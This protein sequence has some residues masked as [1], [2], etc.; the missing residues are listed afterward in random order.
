ME[1]QFSGTSGIT[2]SCVNAVLRYLQFGDSISKVSIVTNK[3]SHALVLYTEHHEV[4]AI[5][6][7]FTS[8]YLGEGPSGFAYVLSLLN[9]QEIE[10]EE[11]YVEIKII[12]KINSSRLTD[13]ELK[14][15]EDSRPVRPTRWHDYV[16]DYRNKYADNK[17][18]LTRFPPVIPFTII[19]PRLFD[20]S[21]SFW[22][23]PSDKILAGYR[24]L[25]DVIRE[26]CDIDDHGS[27]LF[28]KAFLGENSA[29]IWPGLTSGEA[30]GR[31]NLF[32]AIYGGFRNRRA[33][34][35]IAEDSKSQLIEFLALNQLFSLESTSKL[36]LEEGEQRAAL[37]TAG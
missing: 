13:S 6:S 18:L 16:Y 4:I 15:I 24:R 3:Q 17:A 25:E 34:K 30:A 28:Q 31:A 19:D 5:K 12:D 33:H 7:G 37:D 26:R 10:I 27:K 11:Y 32:I 21:V 23:S 9:A 1:I 20:L 14:K 2:Q 36:R 22:K 35:E 8:G 29:L